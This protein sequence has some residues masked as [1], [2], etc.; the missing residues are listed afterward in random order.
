VLGVIAFAVSL[1]LWTGNAPT[2][3]A[4]V[5]ITPSDTAPVSGLPTAPT[6]DP[7]TGSSTGAASGP[8]GGLLGQS[9][10]NSLSANPGGLPYHSIRI[11]ITSDG[12]IAAFGYLVAYGHPSRYVA[13]WLKSPV[14]VDT[15]G[16]SGGI[17]A[18]VGAQAAS[19]A[20][21]VTCTLTID[22]AV[23]SQHTAHGPY[24]FTVCLG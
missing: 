10:P 11:E 14:V 20:T 17:V 6:Q 9:F 5:I 22:G 24:S 18:D 4:V 7:S 1:L 19:N 12:E 3:T 16:R 13:N 2:P 21:Y 23:R 8:L 15:S